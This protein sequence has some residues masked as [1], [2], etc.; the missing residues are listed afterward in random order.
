MKAGASKKEASRHVPMEV[1]REVLERDGYRCTY[2]DPETGRRCSETR[3]LELHHI[4]EW[5]RH[6][7]HDPEFMTL[8][9]R[10]HNDYAA[11]LDYGEDHM[12][13]CKMEGRPPSQGRGGGL[14]H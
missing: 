12:R 14:R 4:K 9:C 5:A 2:V 3:Y 6:R 11:R 7:S 13:R 8:R 10:A 1:R